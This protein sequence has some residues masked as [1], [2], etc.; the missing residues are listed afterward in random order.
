MPRPSADK[1]LKGSDVP[2]GM[3]AGNVLLFQFEFFIEGPREQ[4]R[5]PF[6]A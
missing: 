5:G 3:F 2:G 1:P 4:F 6:D